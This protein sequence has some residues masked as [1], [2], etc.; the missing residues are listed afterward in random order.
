MSMPDKYLNFNQLAEEETKE[1][2]RILKNDRGSPIAVVA[3][4]GGGIEPGTSEITREIAGINFS[5]YIFEGIKKNDNNALHI[6]SSNFDEPECLKLIKKSEFVLS[7][8]GESSAKEIVYVGG[9]HSSICQLIIDN[10]SI[11]GFVTDIHS[12]PR[13]QGTHRNNICNLGRVGAGVQLEI[14]NGLRQ[15][16][17][18]NLSRSRRKNSNTEMKTFCNIIKNCLGQWD[19]NKINS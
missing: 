9:Q 18:S 19:C 12:N 7:I 17:F 10:L 5:Y 3:P 2:Y 1:S 4:H 15:K 16:F 8:H 6:T 13:L 11:N 14:S